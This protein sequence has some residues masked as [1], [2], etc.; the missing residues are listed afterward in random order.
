MERVVLYFWKYVWKSWNCKRAVIMES[1][2]RILTLQMEGFLPVYLGFQSHGTREQGP[3]A[4]QRNPYLAGRG[5]HRFSHWPLLNA[6]WLP[7]GGRGTEAGLQGAH[8]QRQLDVAVALAVTHCFP[9]SLMRGSR[10][11]QWCHQCFMKQRKQSST[12]ER[13]CAHR[14]LNYSIPY[15]CVTP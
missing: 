2:R 5:E 7:D 14:L 4:R 1:K 12:H 8:C 11:L 6:H 3:G 9:C 15:F 13:G 10:G